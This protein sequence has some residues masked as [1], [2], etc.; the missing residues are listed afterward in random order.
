MLDLEFSA[1]SIPGRKSTHSSDY[2]GHVQPVTPAQARSQGWLFVLADGVGEQDRCAVAAK[3]AVE[4]L[5]SGFQAST[6][7][8]LPPLLVRLI[9][10]ANQYV[11]EI[12]KSARLR[13][14]DMAASVVACALRRDRAVVAQAGNPHCYLARQ[15]QVRLLTRSLPAPDQAPLGIFS[16]T[17]GTEALRRQ[18]LSHALGADLFV[19]VEISEHPVLPGDVLALCCD[20]L[21]HSVSEPEIAAVAGQDGDLNAAAQKLVELA[22]DRDGT[23]SISIQLIRIRH[24]E[25]KEPVGRPYKIR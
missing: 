1:L 9:Q 2:V 15:R 11:Y 18:L 12:G 21:Y 17:D 7:E 19:N 13:G 25:S 14:T 4:D 5:V 3:A 10:E 24:V 6:G 16:Q 20:G 23:D 8:P 22:N